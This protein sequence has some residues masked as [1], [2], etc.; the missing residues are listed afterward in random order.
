MGSNLWV[1]GPSSSGRVGQPRIATT[2]NRHR[3][4]GTFGGTSAA[5]PIVSGVAALIREANNALTWRDVKLILAASARK[6]DPDNTGW[7][8]GALEYGSTTDRYSYN[9]EYGFGMVDAKA[10][11]D[12]AAGWTK[13]PEFREITSESPVL[14]LRILDAQSFGT[15]TTVS[16]SL[17]VDP[18][19]EFVEFVEVNTHFDHPRFRNLIVELVSPSGAVSTL[20]TFSFRSGALTT[21]FRFGSARHLGEDAAGE[22]TLRIKDALQSRH[23]QGPSSRGVSPCTATATFRAL[24]IWTL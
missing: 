14:N 12:L 9:E 8:V 1:C 7:E 17:S 16:T 5:T 22:W 10:V 19:V 23:V 21:E 15:G 2:D 13:A 6:N 24:L 18:Y 20:S 11:V 4:S 3:Y